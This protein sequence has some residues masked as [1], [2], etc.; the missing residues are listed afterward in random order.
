MNQLLTR[1]RAVVAALAVA[2]LAGGTVI[3]V[4]AT[5]GGEP[6]A[7]D[8]RQTAADALPA[9]AIRF[10]HPGES[11]RV[12]DFASSGG[13]AH[14]VFVNRSGDD[15]QIC[16]WDTDLESAEQSGGCN[17]AASFFGSHA[18]TL[19][20]AYDGGP[21]ITA[22]RDARIVGLVT[23][24]VTTL[25]VA[26]SDG[27][28]RRVVITRDRAFAYVVPILLLRRGIG[29]VAVAARDQTGAVIDRQVTGIG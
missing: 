10:L 3:A 21:A 22:V 28:S 13:S 20:L 6:R 11:R 17:P 8:R 2:V 18:F 5:R 24:A 26:F 27:S 25:E 1:K 12:A 15:T 16:V 29:P 9:A 7:F 4:A 19:G 23:D 14:A